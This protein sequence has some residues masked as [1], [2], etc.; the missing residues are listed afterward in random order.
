MQHLREIVVGFWGYF[1]PFVEARVLK[2]TCVICVKSIGQA[3]TKIIL[4]VYS[5]LHARVIVF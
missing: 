3:P 5:K 2:A 4:I 1:L